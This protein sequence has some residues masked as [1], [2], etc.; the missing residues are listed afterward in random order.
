MARTERAAL[1]DLALEL[2]PDQPPLSGD[3][4]VRDLVVHLLVREGSP[5]AVGILVP[6]L[7][8]ATDRA[9]RGLARRDFA[10]LVERL[11]NGPPLYSPYRIARL[12]KMFNTLE[13][14]VHHEDIRR[15]QPAWRP[16][17]LSSSQ[18]RALWSLTRGGAKVLM[19]KA[20]VGVV[21]ENAATDERATP[22]QASPTVVVRGLPSELALWA[23]GR[24]EQAEVDL[25]GDA[26]AVAAL[27]D[28]GT[29]R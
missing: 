21:L 28:G 20:K 10:T 27:T 17:A 2:G 11:R 12:D 7:S 3:W 22:K 5:A 16:R 6:G 25:Q 15:A 26:S 18:Q 29:G 23:Y 8:G 19:R 24:R 13:F 14:F 1:C 4:S 9:S